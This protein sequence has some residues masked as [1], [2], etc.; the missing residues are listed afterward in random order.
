M[1]YWEDFKAHGDLSPESEKHTDVGAIS[2]TREIAPGAIADFTFFLA[3]HFPNRT[4]AWCGW[5]SGSG[6]EHEI[7]GNWYATRFSDA[8]AVA[9]YLAGH[10]EALER[11]TS[12]F[13]SA[14]KESTLPPA[15]RDAAASNLTTLISQTCFRTADGEFHGFEGCGDHGGCCH[16][17]CTHVW[18]YETATQFLFPQFAHSLRKAAYGYSMDERGCIYFRQSLP[19]GSG[20]SGFAAADGQMGQIIKTCLD[21]RLS[22]D[23]EWLR[24]VWPKARKAME[25]C[26]VPGRLGR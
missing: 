18:N 12:K 11:E 13:S 16:G 7:I 26:W 19:E 1:L 9:D 24:S 5:E 10:L 6:R 8:W 20:R 21:W 17:N 14:M 2:L 22:G 23:V 15:V 4:P 25:F 3:W